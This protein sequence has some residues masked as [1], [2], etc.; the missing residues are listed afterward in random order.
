MSDYSSLEKLYT[1]GI[2]DMNPKDYIN[3]SSSNV[4]I[5]QTPDVFLPDNRFETVDGNY[6]RREIDKDL[7]QRSN[8]D[9]HQTTDKNIEFPNNNDIKTNNISTKI[10]NVLTSKFVAGA[11]GTLAFLLSG[12]YILKKLHILK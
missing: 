2:L 8:Y 11:V 9:I 3:G 4:Q 6:I 12:R 7:F 5:R 10:T 1:K